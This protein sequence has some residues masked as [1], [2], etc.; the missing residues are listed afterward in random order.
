[1]TKDTK[2]KTL[3]YDSENLKKHKENIDQNM[4]KDSASA[5]LQYRPAAG[6]GTEL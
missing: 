2:T 1:M 3:V 6:S 4:T 5:H